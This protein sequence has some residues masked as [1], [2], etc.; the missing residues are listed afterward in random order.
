M[1]KRVDMESLRARIK[2]R[3]EDITPQLEK[4]AA[5][6][7][8]RPDDVALLSMR[9]LASQSGLPPSTFLRLAR[10]LGFTGY[11]ELQSVFAEWL[12]QSASVYSPRA[13]RL[14]QHEDGNSEVALIREM[15]ASKV[16]N[17]ERSF[18]RSPPEKLLAIADQLLAARRI[19]LVGQRSSFPIVFFF[20]YVLEL[21]S[22]KSTL[23][24]DV[25]GTFADDL[26]YIGPGDVLFVVSFRPYTKNSVLAAEY[27][28]THG[29][30][31]IA[32]TDTELSPLSLRANQ[33]IFVDPSA[34]SFF[35]S[36]VVPLT[37]IEALV[38]VMMARGGKKALEHLRISEAQL[39]QFSAYWDANWK[40]RDK[41]RPQ[42]E[43][44]R[45]QRRAD[46]QP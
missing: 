34:P 24:R 15:F 8:S 14:Q 20:H 5:I 21:F 41:R 38:A 23:I 25:G 30:P 17:L 6:L 36:I 12:R 46:V 27:A 28:R 9:E 2:Q 3:A 4:A 43:A 26:R 13:A 40:P 33:T 7:F 11:P 37:V 18:D 19:Y 44:G 45:L 29:C 32:M 35:D 16:D 31:V 39:S 22:E 1:K 42:V 10:V